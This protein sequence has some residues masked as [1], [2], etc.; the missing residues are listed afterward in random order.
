M[1]IATC[2]GELDGEPAV[3]GLFHRGLSGSLGGVVVSKFAS[4]RIGDPFGEFNVERLV[5]SS[6]VLRLGLLRGLF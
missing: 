3:L 5:G 2:C 6:A 1:S 4:R